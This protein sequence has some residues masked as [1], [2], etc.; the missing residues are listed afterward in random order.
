MTRRGLGAVLVSLAAIAAGAVALASLLWPQQQSSYALEIEPPREALET[1]AFEVDGVRGWVVRRRDGG[2]DA[3][4]ARSPHRGC[5]VELLA[6]DDPRFEARA[7]FFANRRG[8]FLDPCGGSLWL[9]SGERVFG[10][11][12]R[13]LDRF[14]LA[15][16]EAVLWIDLGRVLLGACSDGTTAERCSDRGLP[17]A[18][19]GPR[20]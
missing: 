13:G 10:P 6:P 14:P 5:E 11:A 16:D 8:G 2:L 15:E 12:P 9:L 17:L 20:R 7:D 3:F 1:T 18:T 19:A 4:W